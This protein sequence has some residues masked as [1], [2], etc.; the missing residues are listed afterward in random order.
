MSCKA[1]EV[2]GIKKFFPWLSLLC[3]TVKPAWAL[4][5]W[6]IQEQE[7]MEVWP[8]EDVKADRHR[9]T[10]VCGAIRK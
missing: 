7:D 3:L 5:N 9:D 10:G 2:R 1:Q 8:L 6:T 4:K